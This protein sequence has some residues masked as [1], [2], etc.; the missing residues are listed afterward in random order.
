MYIN[1]LTTSSSWSS[2][3]FPD[4][5]YVGISPSVL[6]NSDV[7]FRIMFPSCKASSGSAFTLESTC[8]ATLKVKTLYHT[9]TFTYTLHL[10]HCITI[11]LHLSKQMRTLTE[12]I[13]KFVLFHVY[14]LV[15]YI[16]MWYKKR[17]LLCTSLTL[18]TLEPSFFCFSFLA[19]DR[20]EC[21]SFSASSS[22][23]TTLLKSSSGPIKS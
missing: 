20:A 6:Q 7:A 15:R 4:C 9:W 2:S 16:Y 11:V 10:I 13:Q 3:R 8:S 19:L 18:L 17:N 23:I 12:N 22:S 1:R 5:P 14:L 21:S